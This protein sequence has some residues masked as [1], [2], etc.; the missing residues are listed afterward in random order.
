[1]AEKLVNVVPNTHVSFNVKYH[2][3]DLFNQLISDSNVGG[4]FFNE[5]PL[6]N[7]VE[8]EG[9]NKDINLSFK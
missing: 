2:T 7:S 3:R 6:I 5:F 4:E 9:C 1:M 8:Y